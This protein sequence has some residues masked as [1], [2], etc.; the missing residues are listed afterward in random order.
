MHR[1]DTSTAQADKFGAGKN[2][3]TG[4]NPQTGQLPTAL[5]QD[6]F[7]AVQEEISRVV[8]AAGIELDKGEYDQLL[9]AL[10]A[11]Y[12]KQ[13]ASLTA[14]SG[15]SGVADRMPYFT[16]AETMALATLTSAGRSLIS[17]A[18]ANEMLTYLGA[19]ALASPTFTG[20]PK[21]P[22]PAAGDNDT[23]IATTAFVVAAIAALSLGNASQRTVGSGA[24]QLPDMSSFTSSLGDAG[25][26]K[27]PS[28]KIKQWGK[29][30]AATAD[31]RYPVT[32]PVP[33]P[34]A[35]YNIQA[36]FGY[37]GAFV[38][39]AVVPEATNPTLTGF[40][41]HRQDIGS[42]FSV[43]TGFIYWEAIGK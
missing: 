13:S 36:T 26:E 37:T 41:A 22:T 10:N 24:N 32:F 8:E 9:T 7:D 6:F 2:G 23:S 40:D 3:F 25:W 5:D 19:A 29:I 12:A 15:L 4:G 16:A 43:P 18:N 17:K 28:G 1:I 39:I 38:N 30:A 20:D 42:T 27:L 33:F 31:T 35:I 14:L 34:S 11:L 21:A